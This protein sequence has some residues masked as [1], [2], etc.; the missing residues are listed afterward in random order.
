[1]NAPELFA[2]TINGAASECYNFGITWGCKSHCPVFMRG[3]CAIYLDNL[4]QFWGELPV[5]EFAPLLEI[6]A[7]KIN[8]E[9]FN[10]IT[11]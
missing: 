5:E 3:D 7:D 9:Q 8:Q 6:Y 4:K 11:T 10:E 2:A 1:M